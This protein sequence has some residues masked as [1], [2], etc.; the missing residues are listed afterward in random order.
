MKNFDEIIDDA[1]QLMQNSDIPGIMSLISDM[2]QLQQVL[3]NDVLKVTTEIKQL[4]EKLKKERL[5]TYC[6]A[7]ETYAWWKDG[8]QYVGCGNLTLKQAKECAK[9]EL[10]L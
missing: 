7:L 1:I 2:K 3:A 6:L 10:I 4:P 5:S 8:V 9:K